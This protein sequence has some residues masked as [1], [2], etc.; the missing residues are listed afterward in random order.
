MTKNGLVSRACAK[1][2][3]RVNQ[4]FTRLVQDFHLRPDVGMS[5]ARDILLCYQRRERVSTRFP[6]AAVIFEMQHG[7]RP[8]QSVIPDEVQTALF[9]EGNTRYLIASG[10][11]NQL[12][13][14]IDELDVSFKRTYRFP[15]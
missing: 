14:L 13:C 12:E 9:C 3:A 5:L 7:S 8:E 2:S 10:P 4:K 6:Y 15:Y 1:K 11:I